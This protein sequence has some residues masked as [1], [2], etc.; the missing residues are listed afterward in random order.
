[1]LLDIGLAGK[2]R[3]FT[4][5]TPKRGL[6]V[7]TKVVTDQRVLVTKLSLTTGALIRL[8]LFVGLK[9]N[10]KHFEQLFSQI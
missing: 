6:A 9:K 3:S 10:Q 8:L 5:G 4:D 2:G 7:V 1:M